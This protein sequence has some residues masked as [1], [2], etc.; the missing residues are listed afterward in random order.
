MSQS[1]PPPVRPGGVGAALSAPFRGLGVL[2]S[3][4]GLWPLALVPCAMAL[5]VMAGLAALAWVYALDWT[6]DL[7]A[8]PPEAGG[9]TWWWRTAQFLAGLA[10]ALAVLVATALLAPAVAEPFL[11]ALA[12][13]VRTV[14]TGTAA[15]PPGGL[16]ANVAAPLLNLSLRL[17]FLLV[18]H[19]VMLPLLVVPLVG[20]VVYGLVGWCLSS[21]V[22][23][24]I[25]LDYAFDTAPRLVPAHERRAFFFAHWPA[26]LT[27]GLAATLVAMV[28]CLTFFLL[29][30]LV[31]GG[32][33]LYLDL[34]GDEALP[35]VPGES[36]PRA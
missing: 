28:P 7:I 15:T 25:Y 6:A 13:R 27:L 36:P 30:V 24:R 17:G 19:V 16:Y 35:G 22:L 29:P 12:R 2:A 34:G 21:L 3:H 4:P 11:G 23:G 26:G 18:A 14:V 9:W 20:W 5:V 8:T 33:L 1:P 32:T 31:A 10:L